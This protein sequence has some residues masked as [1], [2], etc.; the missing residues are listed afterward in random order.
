MTEG[1][2]DTGEKRRSITAWIVIAALGGVIL[3]IGGALLLTNI[4][5][6]QSEARVPFHSVVALNDTITDPAV[7]GRNFPQHYDDYLRT[8]DQTRSKYG[9]SEALPVAPTSADPRSWVSQSRIDEDTRL[10]RMC[11]GYVFA[12][13][14]REERSH[15][16]MLQ[17]QMYTERQQVAQQP[18][19]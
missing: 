13:D 15:A 4:M 2:A 8:V 19:T 11:S 17:D 6:R 3:A 1:T 18:G 7:W 14:F 16:Y 12:T 10:V 5:E 9:G